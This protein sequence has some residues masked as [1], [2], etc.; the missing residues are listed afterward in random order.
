MNQGGQG[1]PNQNEAQVIMQ[2]PPPAPVVPPL[3]FVLGP[4]C[5]NNVLNLTTS[6]A[7]KTYYKAI[8]PLEIKFDGTPEGFIIFVEG[9]LDCI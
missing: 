5:N 4:G 8:T 2:A 3:P 1:E 9:I 6:A 7:C